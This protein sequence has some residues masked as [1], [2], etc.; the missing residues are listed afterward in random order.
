MGTLSELQCALMYILPQHTPVSLYRLKVAATQIKIMICFVTTKEGPIE[1]EMS[2][3]QNKG[4]CT[5]WIALNV[6]PTLVHFRRGN[7][8]LFYYSAIFV[9]INLTLH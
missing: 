6:I 2:Y 7:E 5:M 9:K 4:P 1:A 3:C 8:S